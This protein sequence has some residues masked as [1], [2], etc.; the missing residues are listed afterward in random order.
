[1]S[2]IPADV[3]EREAD[4]VGAIDRLVAQHG[5]RRSS[6]LPILEALREQRR[7]ISDVAMQVVADRLGLPPVEVQGV[8]TFYHFLGTEPTGRHVVHLCRTIS[9]AM[10]GMGAI[11]ER[12]E[13]E[14]GIRFGE[15]TD[16]GLVTLA[17]A[18]CIGMCDRP[19][20]ILLDRQAIGRVTPDDA[21]EL[22]ARLRAAVADDTVGGTPV[23]NWSGDRGPDPRDDD[24]R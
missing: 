20:A 13:N 15:T 2:C 12:L 17:W 10:A 16:D 8:V 5:A 4:L 21:C 7:Q 6:L 11:A 24:S 19:P 22:V 18:N 23:G 9:C 3:L 1:M 14:L